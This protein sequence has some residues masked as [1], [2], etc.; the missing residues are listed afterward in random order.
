VPNGADG[1]GAGVPNVLTVLV[2]ACRK[3]LMVRTGTFSTF[4]TLAPAPR[5]LCTQHL[6][7]S[8]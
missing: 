5:H 4:S 3:M 8:Y 6:G 1:A 7:T 2:P